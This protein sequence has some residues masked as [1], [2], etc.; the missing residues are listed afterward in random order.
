M[1]IQCVY[2]P[3]SL[4][5]VIALKIN[6]VLPFGPQLRII[7]IVHFKF[8]NRSFDLNVVGG[9]SEDSLTLCNLH[10]KLMSSMTGM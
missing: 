9:Q 8:Q 4:L 7:E 6:I 2:P 3:L 1:A 5:L 10:R